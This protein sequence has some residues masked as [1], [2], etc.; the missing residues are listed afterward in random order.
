MK[1]ISNYMYNVDKTK[2]NFE[3]C[4]HSVFVSRPG[5]KQKNYL[6]RMEYVIFGECEDCGV[7]V[8]F[9]CGACNLVLLRPDEHDCV[10]GWGDGQQAFCYALCVGCEQLRWEINNELDFD[11]EEEEEEEE[12]DEGY[13]SGY[14]SQE[15]G[16]ESDQDQDLYDLVHYWLVVRGLLPHQLRANLRG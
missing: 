2:S 4:S 5:Q 13:E 9:R 6:G 12:E 7:E 11:E 15:E 10:V 3:I 1:D 16:E 14:E 8:G